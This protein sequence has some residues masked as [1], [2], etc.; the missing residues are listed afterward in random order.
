MSNINVVVLS[1][2]LGRD[3]EV[4]YTPKGTQIASFNIAVN[5]YRTNQDTGEQIKETTWITC[6]AWGRMG[7]IASQY[8]K[9]GSRVIVHG[10]LRQT[11]WETSD[12]QKRSAIRVVVNNLELPPK[13]E[14]EMVEEEIPAVEEETPFGEDEVP[15]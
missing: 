7:E 1:G 5:R 11:S 3:P 15:F 9:K 10:R 13:A 8:L 6:E 12:G 14:A 2:H 4:R